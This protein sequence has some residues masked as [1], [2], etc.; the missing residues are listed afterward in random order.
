M[1]KNI[2]GPKK[3]AARRSVAAKPVAKPVPAKLVKAKRALLAKAVPPPKRNKAAA[4]KPATGGAAAKVKPAA[5]AKIA[6]PVKAS[7]RSGTTGER[8]RKVQKSAG[9]QMRNAKFAVGQIVRHRIYPFRGVVFDIDPIFANT[10]EWWQAI[11]ADVRPRKDQPFYHLLAENADTEYIAYV[12]EQNLL[13]DDS[14]VPLRHPGISD[15]FVEN[16]DGTLRSVHFQ[17]H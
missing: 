6:V 4:T 10:E 14:G 13:P 5:V 7:V 9:R 8:P 15:Y 3:P 1:A 12:S 2:R 11:P 17:A 16:D